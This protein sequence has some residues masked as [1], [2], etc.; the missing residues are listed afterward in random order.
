MGGSAWG[1]LAS[2]VLRH[3]P[4]EIHDLRATVGSW[5]HLDTNILPRPALLPG[6]SVGVLCGS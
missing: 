5:V 6:L 3:S 2:A 1:G 4:V